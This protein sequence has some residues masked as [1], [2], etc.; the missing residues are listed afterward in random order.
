MRAVKLPPP[1]RAR[2]ARSVMGALRNRQTIRSFSD[3]PLPA[4]L[5]SDLLW[6]AFGINR[7][8]G[9]FSSAGRTAGSASNSQEIDLY[10]AREDGTY[11]YQPAGHRLVPVLG[12][13]LRALALGRG[14]S[15]RGDPG[16]RAPVR[17]V[18]VANLARFEHTQGFDEPGLHAA[19]TQ[20]AY[21]FV[22]T[23]LIAANVYLFAAA[24]GLAAWFH[25]CDRTAIAK[26]LS[27]P[28]DQRVLF[29]QTIGF[30]P[31]RS[32][33]PGSRTSRDA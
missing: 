28:A 16:A 25:N 11:R 19:A 15:R 30:P 5:L 22:D 3:R 33:V 18:F 12:E 23:G 7:R 4:R 14:Q 1:S 6:A 20:K 31:P 10:V 8:R 2:S 29:A 24:H 21:Y 27:L 17:L 32:I 13:D 26:R 9:P